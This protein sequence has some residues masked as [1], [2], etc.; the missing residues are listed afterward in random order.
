MR[1]LVVADTAD[2]PHGTEYGTA[3]PKARMYMN[4]NAEA[5]ND[6]INDD[7]ECLGLEDL[8]PIEREVVDLNYEEWPDDPEELR[9]REEQRQWLA[10][11]VDPDFPTR[12][13]VVELGPYLAAVFEAGTLLLVNGDKSESLPYFNPRGRTDREIAERIRTLLPFS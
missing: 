13:R 5:A 8:E 1:T 11:L 7:T 2:L 10:D 12:T 3:I 9:R 6:Q 4:K